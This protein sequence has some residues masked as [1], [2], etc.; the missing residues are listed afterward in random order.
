[1][2]KNRDCLASIVFGKV[3]ADRFRKQFGHKLLHIFSVVAVLE[4]LERI[5]SIFFYQGNIDF[6]FKISVSLAIVCCVFVPC[7]IL[8]NIKISSSLFRQ[9]NVFFYILT[10]FFLKLSATL[11]HCKSF[12]RAM[13]SVMVFNCSSF[14]AYALVPLSDAFPCEF[15]NT[16][17]RV[18]L[19]VAFIAEAVDFALRTANRASYFETL[20]DFQWTQEDDNGN[21]HVVLSLSNLYDD[22]QVIFLGFACELVLKTFRFPKHALMIVQRVNKSQPDPEVL[23]DNVSANLCWHIFGGNFASKFGL[24]ISKSSGL[25][26]VLLCFLTVSFLVVM[27]LFSFVLESLPGSCLHFLFTVFMMS[28]GRQMLLC[29][30]ADF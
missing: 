21:K 10:S 22:C 11:F 5:G 25:Q 26:I 28:V 17:C 4:I 30:R 29:M 24:W 13:F 2:P 27:Y 1:M 6:T 3:S 12:P 23:P 8:M 20:S 18:G 14:F 19:S 15:R 7:V 16:V 9:G